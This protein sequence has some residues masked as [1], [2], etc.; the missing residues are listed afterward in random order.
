MSVVRC[1][2]AFCSR[3]VTTLGNKVTELIISY[4][5]EK[6]LTTHVRSAPTTSKDFLLVI[7]S[8]FLDVQPNARHWYRLWVPT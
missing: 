7:R 2:S 4:D 3:V 8:I 6:P 1:Q 5:T